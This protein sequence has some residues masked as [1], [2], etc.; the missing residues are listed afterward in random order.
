MEGV[1]KY[2]NFADVIYEGSLDVVARPLQEGE[3]L[4]QLGEPA[5]HHRAQVLHPGRHAAPATAVL[6]VPPAALRVE[7]D[8]RRSLRAPSS[9]TFINTVCPKVR[10]TFEAP[11]ISLIC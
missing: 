9:A 1:Q 10:V 2:E 11:G 3:A 4:R 6:A 5:G 8:G 7:A